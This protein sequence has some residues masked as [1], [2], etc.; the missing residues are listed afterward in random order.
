MLA[1]V[2]TSEAKE[3]LSIVAD[4]VKPLLPN[5]YLKQYH[6]NF[7]ATLSHPHFYYQAWKMAYAIK[8]TLKK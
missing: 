1:S 4:K 8:R 3:Q 2:G 7:V 5:K 6:S